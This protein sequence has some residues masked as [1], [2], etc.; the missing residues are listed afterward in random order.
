MHSLQIIDTDL[1]PEAVNQKD[2]FESG[3]VKIIFII[4]SLVWIQDTAGG[5]DLTL[6]GR[7]SWRN[8]C[9][10]KVVVDPTSSYIR[11]FSWEL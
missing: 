8:L 3:D 1:A 7:V 6:T 5:Q 10:S 4:I 11:I 9:C 2:P